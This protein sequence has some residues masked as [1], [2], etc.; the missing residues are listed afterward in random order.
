[1]TKQTQ[2]RRTRRA[3]KKS[4]VETSRAKQLRQAYREFLSARKSCDIAFAGVDPDND[5]LI[6]LHCFEHKETWSGH[7][8]EL[9]G[10]C[11]KKV[12]DDD[13]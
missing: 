1:V 6:I 7:A 12:A 9:S 13:R 11:P 4:H 2:P 8:A 10:S 3:A 5:G